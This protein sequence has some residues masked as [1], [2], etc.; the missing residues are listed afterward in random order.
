[1][2]SLDAIDDG[3][4]QVWAA[5]QDFRHD[6]TFLSRTAQAASS[7]FL[8]CRLRPEK[9]GF[10]PD[11]M[12]PL[13]LSLHGN[14]SGSQPRFGGARGSLSDLKYLSVDAAWHNQN[15]VNRHRSG[16]VNQVQLIRCADRTLPY[17]R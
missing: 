14:I 5:F 15:E 8:G 4:S 13:G 3:D 11:G 1:M 17:R 10:D 2:L 9:S 6:S 7:K 16:M 12:D